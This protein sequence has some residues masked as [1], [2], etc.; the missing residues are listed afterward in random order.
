MTH[1]VKN[2]RKCTIF[3][4]RALEVKVFCCDFIREPF[5]MISRFFTLCDKSAF[6]L[7][8]IGGKVR[9]CEL[10]RPLFYY[11]KVLA[12]K[13]KDTEDRFKNY[14]RSQNVLDKRQPTNAKTMMPANNCQTGSIFELPPNRKNPE[15][16]NNNIAYNQN[17]QHNQHYHKVIIQS[18][19]NK[20]LHSQVN[21][22]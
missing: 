10:T 16:Q 2:F 20:N 5:P 14:E 11:M 12:K 21:K 9:V 22:N 7:S 15:L 6:D 3:K 19:N 13:L 4:I 1:S 18:N 8:A 17:D